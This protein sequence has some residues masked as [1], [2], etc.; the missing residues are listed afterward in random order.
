MIE[1]TARERQDCGNT[2]ILHMRECVGLES[3]F[4]AVLQLQVYV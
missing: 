4:G 3:M 1:Q 2:D